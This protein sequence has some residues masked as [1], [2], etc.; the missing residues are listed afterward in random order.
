[1]KT[2]TL[3][4]TTFFYLGY[5]AIAPG[6]V[7]TLGGVIFYLVLY[8]SRAS[9]IVYIIIFFV[10]CFFGILASTKAEAYFKEKDP[11]PIVIDEVLGYLVTMFMIPLSWPI[12]L[13]GFILN[14]VLDIWKPFP[15]DRAQRLSG[16]WGIVVDDLISGLYTNFLLRGMIY[17][18]DSF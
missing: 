1:M 8:F 16:G 17:I 13:I 3:L 14:R 9:W 15:A 18:F 12:F 6:T 4:F 10:L 7:G 2:L 11:S 5:S